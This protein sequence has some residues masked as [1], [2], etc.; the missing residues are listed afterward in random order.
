MDA[1]LSRGTTPSASLVSGRA[2][3]VAS[4]CRPGPSNP[5]GMR[6]LVPFAVAQLPPQIASRMSVLSP[7]MTRADAD[8]W[9][10]IVTKHPLRT[11]HV[12]GC[13]RCPTR[14]RIERHLCPVRIPPSLHV[15]AAGNSR[16]GPRLQ[17]LGH[18][19]G[20]LLRRRRR[21]RVGGRDGC[22]YAHR[23]GHCG[24]DCGGDAVLHAARPPLFTPPSRLPPAASIAARHCARI[25]P[26][27]RAAA[28]RGLR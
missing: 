22:R 15:T 2:L 23:R 4:C 3:R 12:D 1:P 10:G 19:D 16:A 20:R 11:S 25:R 28:G 13:S 6:G 8:A 21:W 17:L 7:A 18:S 24:E 27:V 5:R 26:R 14:A 9:G